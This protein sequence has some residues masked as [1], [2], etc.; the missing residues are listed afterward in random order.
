M[1]RGDTGERTKLRRKFSTLVSG[2]TVGTP[3]F[4]YFQNIMPI[5]RTLLEIFELRAPYACGRRLRLGFAPTGA[6]S[7]NRGLARCAA[8]RRLCSSILCHV[9]HPRVCFRQGSGLPQQ[10]L[11]WNQVLYHAPKPALLQTLLRAYFLF[12]F[13]RPPRGAYW[14]P[15]QT[16]RAMKDAQNVSRDICCIVILNAYTIY[17]R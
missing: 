6:Y 4:V 14:P 11:S 1:L 8:R 15:Y 17:T 10:K 13:S 16:N 5:A 2:K 3:T 7:S 9:L 12:W